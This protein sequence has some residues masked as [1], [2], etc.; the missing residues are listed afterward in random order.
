MGHDGDVMCDAQS[1]STLAYYER[2]ARSFCAATVALDLSALYARFLPLLPAGGHILDV[3]CGSGRDA[4]A[5]LAQGYTVTAFDASPALAQQARAYC[6]IPVQVLRV[7]EGPWMACFDGIWARASL[8][9]VPMRELPEVLGRLT[10]ALKPGGVLYLSFKYG[11]GERH[12]EGRHF[13]DLD[14]AGLLM[15]LG[16]V[17]GLLLREQWITADQRPERHGEQWLNAVVA[18]LA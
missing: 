5:F 11:H 4:R 3:G 14:E 7:Q 1:D 8:L 12:C 6:G 16:A 10:V 9:H 13:T 15:L 17:P 18:G 2:N